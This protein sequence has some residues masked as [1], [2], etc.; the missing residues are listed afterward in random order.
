[1]KN[2]KCFF[3]VCFCVVIYVIIFCTLKFRLFDNLKLGLRDLS[4]FDQAIWNLFNNG[5]LYSSILGKSILGE[6][7]FFIMFL[8]APFYLIHF[9]PKTLLF[10]ESFFIGLGALPVYFLAGSEFKSKS[11][12]VIFAATYLLFPS[13][14]FLNMDEVI[15]GFHP[16]SL[17]PVLYLSMFIFLLKRFK[18][19]FMVLT[20]IALSVREDTSLTICLIGI[21]AI[22]FLKE[23]R[24]GFATVLISILWFF[25]TT[26]VIIPYFNDAPSRFF[27]NYSYLG[28]SLWE[29]IKLFLYHQSYIFNLLKS[30]GLFIYLFVLLAPF[31]FSSLFSPVILAMCFPALLCN[32]LTNPKEYLIPHDYVSWHIAPIIP[33]V[34]ISSIYGVKRI[35]AVLIMILKGMKG[36]LTNLLS[37]SP[38]MLILATVIISHLFYGV[39]PLSLSFWDVNI[40]PLTRYPFSSECFK[41]KIYQQKDKK[42]L[43]GEIKKTIPAD[44]SLSA[45]FYIGSHFAHRKEIYWFPQYSNAAEYV[46]LDSL[47]AVNQDEVKNFINKKDENYKLIYRKDHVLLYK[48]CIK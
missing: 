10:L 31:A 16:S 30:N 40:Y 20:F 13:T 42:H 45:T 22:I 12:G 35:R 47:R 32:L 15:Y 8:F 2:Q 43:L 18:V 39:T 34:L 36:K 48:R 29:I 25:L 14:G 37:F 5:S 6:H 3:Y 33:F 46:L 38:V 24:L 21:Y 1:M 4:I 26:V 27:S 17:L 41:S 44:A 11:I 23:I 9:D 19:T 28:H 7:A